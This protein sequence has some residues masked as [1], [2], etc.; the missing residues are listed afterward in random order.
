MAEESSYK[1]G[2]RGRC[3]GCGQG[4]QFQQPRTIT[5]VGEHLARKEQAI[6][7]FWLEDR[8]VDCEIHFS[9]CP[10][11]SHLLITGLFAGE[12]GDEE[13]VLWPKAGAPP[14]SDMV[15][16]EL[17]ADFREAH[18]VLPISSKSAAALARRCLEEILVAK[19]SVDPK[20]PLAEMIDAVIGTL[21]GYIAKDLDAVRA[22]GVL[23]VHPKRSV[24][25]GEIVSVGPGE[26][27]LTLHIISE[28]FDFYYVKPA[29]SEK[30]RQQLEGKWK[31]VGKPDLKKPK[32][33]GSGNPEVAP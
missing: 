23:A 1:P 14:V 28:L 11:C 21:P 7:P 29:E 6:G 17:A 8:S 13:K 10:I 9:Q 27:E 19:G 12:D 33:S 18:A 2:A 16:N 24:R 26:A 15:P 3:P 25:T 22:T 32:A 30:I 31:E 4:V 5:E 20:K